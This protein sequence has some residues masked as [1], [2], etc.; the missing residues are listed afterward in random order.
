MQ[1]RDTVDP[2]DTETLFQMVA[3]D[4]RA[5]MTGLL[6]MTELLAMM[7]P[8]A[9]RDFLAQQARMAHG[10]AQQI[11]SLLENLLAWSR[12]QAGALR[13][14]PGW[15]ALTELVQS[16]AALWQPNAQAKSITLTVS[17]TDISARTD[18]ALLE[19]ILRNL[20]GNAVKFTP[21]G[22]QIAITCKAEVGG[23][24]IEV[25]DSGPGLTNSQIEA[26]HDGRLQ[27]PGRGSEGEQG[28]GLGLTLCRTLARSLDAEL[29]FSVPTEGGTLARVS[30][31]M[32]DHP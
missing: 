21:S 32:A 18:A 12:M 17:G 31:P 16:V 30:L 10:A 25:H 20:V 24:V 6:G 26:F 1:P 9:D 3:H 28:S 14:R 5:P 4:L 2:Q 27:R 13:V 15:V 19:G 29:T 7:A 23:V 22:G 8:T 11:N